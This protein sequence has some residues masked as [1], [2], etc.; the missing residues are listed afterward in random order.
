MRL[1]VLLVLFTACAHGPDPSKPAQAPA[2]PECDRAGIWEQFESTLRS[3]YAYLDRGDFDVDGL[4][5]RARERAAAAKSVAEV[6]GILLRTT[7]AFTDPHLLVGPLS[8]D[9]FNVIFTSSDLIAEVRDGKVQVTEVRRDSAAQRAGVRPGWSVRSVNGVPMESA[10]AE[11]FAELLDTPT[12]HQQSYAA[13]LIL[14]GAREGSR[15][16]E[17]TVE[18]ES[19]TLNL[20]NPRALAR[21]VATRQPLTVQVA[22]GGVTVFRFENSL[23][24]AETIAAFDRAI[25]AAANS[26][27]VILDLRNTPSGGN[28]DVARAIIGHF[29]AEARPYQRHRIPAVE[30]QTGVP[31]MFVEYVMPRAPRYSGPL[32][33]L[34]GP[35]TGSMGEGL[36]IGLDAAAGAETFASDMG[37]LLGALYSRPLSCELFL[38]YGGESLFHV[39]DTPREAYRARHPME[40]GEL[41]PDGSDPA[42]AA[43]LEFLSTASR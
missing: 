42:L 5:S 29:V 41:G 4:L 39:D 2:A 20:E 35:W 16:I 40:H 34:G 10:I 36:V 27:G 28:T 19:R 9:D 32:A 12:A 8:A 18:G 30:R 23:G 43:A 31:R 37:D 11:V 15:R 22:D 7:Y 17:F 24:K 3:S 21:E 25:Q 33:V 38:E 6:R 13:S 14:N 1:F 26:T